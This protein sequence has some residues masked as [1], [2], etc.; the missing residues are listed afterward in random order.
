L[1]E[2]ASLPSPVAGCG[3]EGET[4]DKRSS[5]PVSKVIEPS[6]DRSPAAGDSQQPSQKG[7]VTLLAGKPLVTFRTAQEFLK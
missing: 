4:I 5:P 7:D 6:V 3:D 1:A 2:G